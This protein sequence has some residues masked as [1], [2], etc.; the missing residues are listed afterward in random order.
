M[1][2]PKVT[3]G[4]PLYNAGK[5]LQTALS[6]LL[7]QD[8]T[9]FEIIACDN[10]SNDNTG[11]ILKNFLAKDQRLKVVYNSEN[12]GSIKNFVKVLD[13]ANSEY[14]MW[15]AHDDGWEPDYI[16][17]CVDVLEQHPQ[18]VLCNSEIQFMDM[19]GGEVWVNPH[20]KMHTFQM[21]LV[22]RV[23]TLIGTNNWYSIYGVMRTNMLKKINVDP[24]CWGHDVVQLMQLSLLGDFYVIP[25]VL[26]HYRC[27]RNTHEDD[28]LQKSLAVKQELT[29]PSYTYLAANLLNAITQTNLPIKEK[30][31][32]HTKIIQTIC[33]KNMHWRNLVLQENSSMRETIMEKVASARMTNEVLF[34]LFAS[35]LNKLAQHIKVDV[36]GSHILKTIYKDFSENQN[37]DSLLKKSA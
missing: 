15:A 6:Q 1:M 10:N 19:N 8:Y 2:K 25:E 33:F 37:L 35:L 36:F 27:L 24:V 34:F 13:L 26:F 30:Y 18:V 21:D 29:R 17:K 20:N 32:L 11:E 12:I 9:N 28:L 16:R 14:F 3:I 23:E 7:A 22:Q 5:Y 31:S 4:M